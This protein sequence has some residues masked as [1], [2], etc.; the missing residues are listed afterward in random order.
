M[1]IAISLTLIFF[2]CLF[3]WRAC[4][5]FEFAS[6]YIGRK[7]SEGVRG[8][9]INAVSSSLPELFTTFIALFVYADAEGFTVGIGTTAG[10]AL[11]NG[12]IIPALCIL[13]VVGR[14]VAG[15][16][17]T[18]VDVSLKV[19]LRDGLTLLAAG[20]LL[21]YILIGAQLVWWQGLVLIVFYGFYV[22][23][24]ISSMKG[25]HAENAEL[26]ADEDPE[27]DPTL[28]SGEEAKSRLAKAFYWLSLGP[29]LD[30]ERLFIKQ[31]QHE[32]IQNQTWNGWPLL[33]TAGAIMG[34]SCYVLV[35]GCEWLGTG[36]N[37]QLHPYF[38]LWGYQLVG[39]G[40][41]SVFVAV[42]FAAMATSVPDTIISIR[43]ARDGDYDDAVANALGSN[44]FDICFALGLP[45]FL[46]TLVHGPIQMTPIAAEQS[47]ELRIILWILTVAT[48][49]IFL[50]GR[51]V[52]NADGFLTVQLTRLNAY[53][54]LG[55]YA[56]FL[57]Y[58]IG[59]STDAEWALMIGSWL[60]AYVNGLSL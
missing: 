43:D 16:R 10:S 49:L 3:I 14:V 47:G 21:L 41:P 20:T 57:I 25:S 48:L 52:R 19:I 50:A 37:N 54:L 17:V 31:K 55:L 51:Y 23:Y 42:I 29:L 5:G 34:L 33:V 30:L 22:G 60:Q 8:A 12:M 56:V 4:D 28:A 15:T 39:L 9:T 26:H 36:P 53:W 44:I 38:E 59:R 27:E 11:F 24:A 1:G 2:S 32:Q 58:I 45:L 46:Y 35:K 7:L 6:E 13:F 18:T 40:M